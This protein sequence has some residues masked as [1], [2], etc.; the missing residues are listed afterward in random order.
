MWMETFRA[1][2]YNPIE[3]ASVSGLVEVEAGTLP[4]RAT[5]VLT[6]NEGF[7]YNWFRVGE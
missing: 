4:T 5:I 7:G 2:L 1:W 6:S 3:L